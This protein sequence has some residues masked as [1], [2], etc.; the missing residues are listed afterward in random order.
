[1]ASNG[2]P[3]GDKSVVT[4]DD[5]RPI[6]LDLAAVEPAALVESLDAALLAVSHFYSGP[7]FGRYMARYGLTEAQT[8]LFRAIRFVRDAP[9]P[10][11]IKEV[12]AVVSLSHPATSRL[13]NRCVAAGFID[14]VESKVDRRHATLT[15]TPTGRQ[16]ARK[17]E[18]ARREV[19]GALV[20]EWPQAALDD[21]L[22]S[23]QRLGPE[24]RR[25][26]ENAPPALDAK[27]RERMARTKPS[28]P[29]KSNGKAR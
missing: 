6:A 14:R 21:L 26:R 23:L 5:E 7:T 25:L 27:P 15:I 20:A 2:D 28:G 17:V 8:S 12:Q 22:S 19:V 13:I 1:M 4:T 3:S 9:P 11:S 29:T 18:E 24:F 10:V 16:A